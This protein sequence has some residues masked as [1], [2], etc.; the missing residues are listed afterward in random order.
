MTRPLPNIA[1]QKFG[2]WTVEKLTDFKSKDGSRLWQCRCECGTVRNLAGTEVKRT[3]SCGCRTRRGEK[4]S[5]DYSGQVYGELTV[6][7]EAVDK[8]KGNARY[9]NCSCSCGKNC[10]VAQ[11]NFRS[12][13]QI[14]CGHL[15][16]QTAIKRSLKN[17]DG[18]ENE[19][20]GFLKVVEVLP[21]GS[22]QRGPNLKCLCQCG[23]EYIGQAALILAGQVR[24]CGCYAKLIAREKVAA[25]LAAR[26]KDHQ[27]KIF[28]C[29]RCKK[30]KPS[31]EFG[32]RQRP[33]SKFK[34]R[35]KYCKQ[36]DN[37][38]RSGAGRR[39]D[40]GY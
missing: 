23:N 20:F 27:Y 33:G 18:I 31:T 2:A 28:T 13:K 5:Q 14:S 8:R 29:T 16:D 1:G 39:T 3:K 21:G 15:R 32:V 9:W 10:V 26:Y 22:G 34:N 7:S 4:I 25:A 11:S 35:L 38:V 40:L 6:L 36:C 37:G 19:S 30:E 12:G 24:S 17:L